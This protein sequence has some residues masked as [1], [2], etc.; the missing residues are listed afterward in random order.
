MNSSSIQLQWVPAE[1]RPGIMGIWNDR[2]SGRVWSTRLMSSDPDYFGN[3]SPLIV[4]R[5]SDSDVVMVLAVIKNELS[6]DENA[7]CL[8]LTSQ[9]MCGWMPE[10]Q[11][12]CY[13]K[14]S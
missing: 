9:G 3:P 6:Y 1:I 10:N 7:V 8:V 13:E 12:S 4:G 5:L 14:V 2:G 11:L